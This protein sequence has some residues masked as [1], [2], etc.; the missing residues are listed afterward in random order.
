MRSGTP[1]NR[2]ILRQALAAVLRYLD[3]AVVGAGVEQPFLLRRL[4]QGG[5][6][7]VER[8]RDALGDRVRAPDFAHH[9]QLIAVELARQVAADR[10]PGVAA[11]VAAE[12]LVGGEVEP[13]VGMRADDER[14]VPVP[15]QRRLPLARLRLDADALAGAPIVA[16]QDAVLGFGVDGV[17][18]LRIDTASG[19]RRLPGSRTS[20]RW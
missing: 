14:R 4:G 10:F 3:Q 12:E 16:D 7:A 17:G 15:A 20:R 18:I 1:G 5:D 6:V 19:S 13:G 8:G 11:V 9:R 2:S